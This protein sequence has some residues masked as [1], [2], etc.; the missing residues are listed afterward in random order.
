MDTQSKLYQAKT[1][2]DINVSLALLSVIIFASLTVRYWIDNLGT[3]II[4]L[5]VVYRGYHLLKDARKRIN[6]D[7]NE[8]H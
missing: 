8:A 6:P 4:I 1:M 7:Q 5:Y 2:V 3:L